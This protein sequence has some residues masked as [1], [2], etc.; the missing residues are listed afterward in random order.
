V[1]NCSLSFPFARA[2][3][4]LRPYAVPC[5]PAAPAGPCALLQ[6]LPRGAR[7]DFA[8]GAD[9]VLAATAQVDSLP[10][11]P[12]AAAPQVEEPVCKACKMP[13][14]KSNIMF[15]ICG[16]MFQF[17]PPGPKNSGQARHAVALKPREA[18]K[19]LKTEW[20]KVHT[21][22]K[23][24]A[25]ACE[26]LTKVVAC[27]HVSPRAFARSSLVQEIQS[28]L[29]QHKA[30]VDADAEATKPDASRCFPAWLFLKILPVKAMVEYWKHACMLL[31]TQ[32]G[33]PFTWA[34]NCRI[35]EIKAPNSV[36]ARKK[37]AKKKDGKKKEVKKTAKKKA[38]KKSGQAR[39]GS[40][41]VQDIN[42][43]LQQHKAGQRND[44]T[45][46][47]MSKPPTSSPASRMGGA[48]TALLTGLTVLSLFVAGCA[49]LEP[50][51]NTGLVGLNAAS[52]ANP[53]PSCTQDCCGWL[54]VLLVLKTEITVAPP[55][56]ASRMGGAG[57]ALLLVG[58]VVL[59][60]EAAECVWLESSVKTGLV[61]WK[62]S[63]TA[64]PPPMQT[65]DSGWLLVFLVL[66]A[67]G[68]WGVACV[69]QQHQNRRPDRERAFGAA[70]DTIC[71]NPGKG[72]GCE[73][74][75]SRSCS[76]GGGAPHRTPW[77]SFAAQKRGL[78]RRGRM[79]RKRE[80][81]EKRRA[82]KTEWRETACKQ[83]VERGAPERKQVEMQKE[84]KEVISALLAHPL[85]ARI[86]REL[87]PATHLQRSALKAHGQKH[88]IFFS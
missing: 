73:A 84:M 60:L 70:G 14:A 35:A 62:A 5:A 64:H 33:V 16:R 4:A 17:P 65:Q 32:I 72:S 7:D 21:E 48:E 34:F 71:L 76:G 3:R 85:P 57:K 15:G 28:W 8:T 13:K 2:P 86:E 31:L 80:K 87:I 78:S 55:P 54:L 58:L 9:L 59:A 38:K 11:C 43:W 47:E 10:D 25:H 39:H 40:S 42:R 29:Q 1:T 79:A 19:A 23:T 77:V 66:R 12:A 44:H 53:A 20:D 18:E 6:C 83:A 56:A 68:V 46:K 67:F 37:K 49:W 22:K 52:M 81:R 74:A 88:L 41:L 27:R 50:D 26:I 75:D 61:D 69:V 24:E 36:G 30:A 82:M 51:V 63:S 45:K